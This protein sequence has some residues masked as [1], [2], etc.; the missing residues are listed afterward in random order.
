[1][2]GSPGGSAVAR[3][4]GGLAYLV[5]WSPAPGFSS[6]N[7]RRGPDDEARVRFRSGETRVMLFV[8]CTGGVP[9][10]QVAVEHDD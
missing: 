7:A 10:G 9:H 5:S 6:D 1:V 8:T 3:C 2:L 4:T